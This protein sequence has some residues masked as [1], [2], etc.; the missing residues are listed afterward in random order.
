MPS[1]AKQRH[2]ID[3]ISIAIVSED[4]R[5]YYAVSN[6]FNPKDADSWVKEN[7]IDKLEVELFKKQ[8]TNIIKYII[9]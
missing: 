6:E 2:F 7:V 4:G 9:P 8:N 3:L 5:E 1:F